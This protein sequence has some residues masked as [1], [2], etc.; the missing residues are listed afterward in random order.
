M[1]S[2][3]LSTS[4]TYNHGL[5]IAEATIPYL[6]LRYVYFIS[7]LWPDG[8]SQ[9]TTSYYS[10]HAC[11]SMTELRRQDTTT[12]L[13]NINTTVDNDIMNGKSSVAK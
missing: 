12:Y 9:L 7:I 11:M 13:I 3:L 2:P 1:R 4:V 8:H 5:R 10:L 6:N